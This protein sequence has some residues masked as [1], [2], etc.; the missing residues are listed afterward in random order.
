MGNPMRDFS[1]FLGLAVSFA[2]VLAVAVGPPDVRAKE[3]M[4]SAQA[5]RGAAAV[6]GEAVLLFSLF[7][8]LVWCALLPFMDRAAVCALLLAG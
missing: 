5:A 2:A 6:D 8:L 7:G 4:R 3:I 1:H